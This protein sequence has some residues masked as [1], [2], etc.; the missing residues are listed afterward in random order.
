MYSRAFA[1]VEHPDMRQGRIR[2]LRHKAAKGI[3][4]AD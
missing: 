4:F 2:D 1:G 3:D